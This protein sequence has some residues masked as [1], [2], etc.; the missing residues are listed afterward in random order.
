M[1]TA[2]PA[3][4][5][6]FSV[7]ATS[8]IAAT[9]KT[10]DVKNIYRDGCTHQ[11]DLDRIP[12]KNTKDFMSRVVSWPADPITSA[13][14]VDLIWT[15]GFSGKP[16]K[17]VSDFMGCVAWAQSK[18]TIKDIYYCL[19]LQAEANKNGSGNLTAKRHASLA[20]S[21]K[22]IWLDVDVKDPPKGYATLLD[23]VEAV[24]AF[25]AAAGLPAPSAL[26]HSGGGLH[27]YWISD[28]AL[29]KAKWE[30]YAQGLKALALEHELRCDAGITTDAARILRVPNTLNYKTD[31]PKPVKLLALRE[32]SLDY[33]FAR[34]LGF[35]TN[36]T[37]APAC[38]GALFIE[39]NQPTR[40]AA[41]FAALP[42]ESLSEGLDNYADQPPLALQSITK[43]CAFI[44]DALETGGKDYSQPMWNLTTLAATFLEG[45]KKLAHEMGNQHPEYNWESTDALWARKNRER[46]EKGLGWPSCQAIQDAGCISC[47]TCPHV[48]KGK[49]PLHLGLRSAPVANTIQANGNG[50]WP[51][52]PDPLG[53]HQVPIEEAI[54]RVNEAGYFVLTLNGDI[55]KTEPGGGITAQKREGFNTLFACR[56]AR[57]DDGKQ[58]PA[59]TAWKCS[60]NRREYDRIGY[61]PGDYGRPPQS[62]NLWQ[63]WGIEP[64]KGDWSIIYDHIFNVVANG[65]KGKATYILDFCAHMLQRPWEK[66]G[67][68]LVLRGRKGTGKSLLTEILA[69]VVGKPN[70]L[71][72][73]SGKKLFAQFNWHVADKLLI[74]AEEAFF[75]GNRELN[76]QL[77]HLLTGDEI[78]VEQKYGQRI[79]I[80]SMHRMIMTSNHDQVIAASDDERRYFVCDV[81]DRR[82]GDDAYFAP[83][84]K[85]IKGEDDV[86]LAA[87]MYELQKRNI[88]NWKP[89]KA[90]RNAA[91]IDLARQKLMSLE[92]PLQWLL[93][94]DA[95]LVGV[96]VQTAEDVG[97]PADAD[98]QT[99][100]RIERMG[101]RIPPEQHTSTREIQKDHMLESYRRWAKDAQVRGAT[102]YTAAE[103]FWAKIKRILNKE[104]FPGR[105]LFR[106]SGGKR[107]VLLPPRQEMAEAFNRLLGGKVVDVDE[108][109]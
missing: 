34:T 61:W 29:P 27:V 42:K 3:D 22:A 28:R 100:Q 82:R 46:K 96:A 72:T 36:T 107:F 15:P 93:E 108:D 11:I 97:Y 30:P 104:I 40:P 37:A 48:S 62:Y 45:G 99:E 20:L 103:V 23:A 14:Y 95:A 66:P 102:D 81:S 75:V 18:N 65:D 7:A 12:S 60:T 24:T 44:R 39:N 54:T 53:F 16:F 86:T 5:G 106:S 4:T 69:R 67:V 13:G 76:D 17:T 57:G 73:A 80:K 47:A 25:R 109:V 85:V 84:V 10:L 41:A 77:K 71:I 8:G 32:Q 51:N 90:A 50:Q 64:K 78:E 68:A 101:T 2:I 26:V 38:S 70:T 56:W 6:N 92:P 91:S 94:Q 1:G 88:Q 79:S 55:Y 49:S 9:V 58:I 98:L 33:D 21:L 83:L 35:L 89:E 59:G 74:G 31:P 63:C 87:F 43:E 52:R 105:R 19:S